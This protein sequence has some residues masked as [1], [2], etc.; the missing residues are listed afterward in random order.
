MTTKLQ[1]T[2]IVMQMDATELKQKGQQSSVLT[3]STNLLTFKGSGLIILGT[4]ASVIFLTI[5]ISFNV[6]RLKIHL[7]FCI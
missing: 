7:F 5:Y 3:R 4:N 2:H 6:K 1:H